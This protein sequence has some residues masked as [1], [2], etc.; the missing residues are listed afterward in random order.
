MRDVTHSPQNYSGDV[1][2]PNIIPVEFRISINESTGLPNKPMKSPPSSA[3]CVTTG[4]S[5][6]TELCHAHIPENYFDT[7]GDAN[8][9]VS[10]IISQHPTSQ[11]VTA[12]RSHHPTPPSTNVQSE[13]SVK[14]PSIN[15]DLS[16]TAGDKEK[17]SHAPSERPLYDVASPRLSPVTPATTYQRAEPTLV[18][19]Q[20]PLFTSYT[21]DSVL[22]S[23][24]FSR[25]TADL[26]EPV[27][28]SPL[29]SL[30]RATRGEIPI[31]DD[32][33]DE[34]ATDGPFASPI[35]S[36]PPPRIEVIHGLPKRPPGMSFRG[37]NLIRERRVISRTINQSGLERDAISRKGNDQEKARSHR[38]KGQEARS[39]KC[40]LNQPQVVTHSFHYIFFF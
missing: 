3:S 15:S 29:Y 27:V 36:S 31:Q 11:P 18:Y 17:S 38:P 1:S 21:S 40:R 4:V 14:S 30:G 33:R 35:S 10:K 32:D 16:T 39:G 5:G 26:Q 8:E 23:P 24:P 34:S 9:V 2:T 28:D 19:P 22:E 13:W 6:R 7:S 37:N 25:R 12:S 20:T